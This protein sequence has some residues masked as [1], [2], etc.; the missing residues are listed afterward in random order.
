MK[1]FVIAVFAFLLWILQGV[2]YH[3][4]WTWGLTATLEFDRQ[5]AVEGEHAILK[6]T[7]S[8]AKFLPLIMLHVKFQMGKYLVFTSSNNFKIK[9]N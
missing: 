7:I 8:N 4:L 1:L 9:Y 6:E 2:L 3:S 5:H